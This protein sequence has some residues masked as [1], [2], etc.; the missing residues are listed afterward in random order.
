MDM[1][2]TLCII[3]SLVVFSA[4]KEKSNDQPSGSS[5]NSSS[6]SLE[7]QV[8]A[9]HDEVMPKMGDIHIAKKGLKSM[10]DQTQNDSTKSFILQLITNLENADEGMMVWM[11]SWKVPKNEPEKTSYLKTELIKVAK[12]KEDML[13]SIKT[14]NQFILEN[15]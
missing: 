7:D 1:R 11:E 10:L 6:V 4:C 3:F 13:S 14:A 9:I 2:I 12:V 15:K 8:M 5:T